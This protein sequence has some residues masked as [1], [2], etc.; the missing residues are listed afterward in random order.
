MERVELTTP[1]G[2][3]A[4]MYTRPDTS[5]LSVCGATFAGVAGSGLVDEYGLA[6]FYL[7]GRFVDVGA[8]I[9]SV[10]VAVLLD[11]PKATAVCVEPLREN[12]DILAANLSANGLSDRARI[13]AGAAGTDTVHYDWA[14]DET[15]RTNRY[16]GNLNS[17]T[18]A[19][20]TL[21]V[22]R[23]DLADLLPADAMKLDCEGGEW[24]ILGDPGIGEVHYLFGEYH[25]YPGMSGLLAMLKNTHRVEFVGNQTYAGNFRAVR[26]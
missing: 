12:R 22:R 14:G 25:G 10:T 11:N 20:T 8:H 17:P 16:I 24:A 9:G 26:L 15:M 18:T 5:D 4:I 7:S 13:I 6:D 1:R 21:D 2:R 23:V 3:P 19:A